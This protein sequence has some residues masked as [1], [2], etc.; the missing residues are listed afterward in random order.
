MKEQGASVIVDTLR[1]K[2]KDY[3]LLKITPPEHMV[4]VLQAQPLLLLST[5]TVVLSARSIQLSFTSLQ[6]LPGATVPPTAQREG[7][8]F[9][10][11]PLS[12]LF[13]LPRLLHQ[14][15]RADS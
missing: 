6:T 10:L 8:F 13:L 1:G 14:I 3:K 7:V 12:F 2:K 11:F 15:R 5:G 9:F 4:S